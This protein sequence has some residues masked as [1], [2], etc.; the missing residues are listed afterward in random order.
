MTESRSEL[1]EWELLTA[2]W[3]TTKAALAQTEN[4]LV[5]II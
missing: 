2:D 4:E 3:L 5:E 1:I